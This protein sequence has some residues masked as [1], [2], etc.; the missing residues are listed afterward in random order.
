LVEGLVCAAEGKALRALLVRAG[1]R[2][3]FRW[4]MVAFQL[5]GFSAG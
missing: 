4:D 3:G 5:V 2:R 1:R